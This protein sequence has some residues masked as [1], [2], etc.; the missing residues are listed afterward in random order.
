MADLEV[1]AVVEE[2]SRG[3]MEIEMTGPTIETGVSR[4]GTTDTKVEAVV[5]ETSEEEVVVAMIATT[6]IDN[7]LLEDNG[8]IG[9]I[10][11][12]TV[13]HLLAG[14]EEVPSADQ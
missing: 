4:E 13:D 7:L 5:E 3:T 6:T 14:I 12:T 10:V 11:P 1:L 9:G 8:K 2:A